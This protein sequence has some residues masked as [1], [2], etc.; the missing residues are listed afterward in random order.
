VEHAH[1]QIEVPEYEPGRFL[2]DVTAGR[3]TLVDARFPD[4]FRTATLPGAINWPIVAGYGQVRQLQAQLP[5]DKPIVVFCNNEKCGWS[6][7]VASQLIIR[8]YRDVFIY[9]PGVVGY[10][11][12]EKGGS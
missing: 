9:R 7:A 10:R 11:Q 3:L 1:F 5:R 8:G 4:A 6:D 12:T 2:T